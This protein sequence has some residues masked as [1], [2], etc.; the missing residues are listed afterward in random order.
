MVAYAAAPTVVPILVTAVMLII[1]ISASIGIGAS[2]KLPGAMTFAM[3]V[4][5]VALSGLAYRTLRAKMSRSKEPLSSSTTPESVSMSS[6]SE[7]P[8]EQSQPAGGTKHSASPLVPPRMPA[9]IMP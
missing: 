6:A 4:G 2:E 3:V 5:S 7:R 1:L 8:A 9:S